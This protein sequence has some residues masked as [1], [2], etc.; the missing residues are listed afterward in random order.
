M[1]ITLRRNS[2][3]VKVNP[4]YHYNPRSGYFGISE[5]GNKSMT[6]LVYTDGDPKEETKILFNMLAKG[7]TVTEDVKDKMWHTELEDGTKIYLRIDY[8]TP[9]HAPAVMISIRKS[10]DPAGIRTQKIHFVKKGKNKK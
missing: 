10:N 3:P 8:P 1:G 6:R 5:R 9:D 4:F 7:A 2:L